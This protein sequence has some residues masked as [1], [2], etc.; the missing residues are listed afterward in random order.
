MRAPMPCPFGFPA[1]VGVKR[2]LAK[3]V[4]N[5]R[6]RE[7]L[8][9]Y[10]ELS[11]LRIGDLVRTCDGLNSRVTRVEPDYQEFRHGRVLI[12]LDIITDRNSCSLYH[13]G[14]DRPI[15]GAQALAYR[16]ALV[17]HATATG[18]P[19]GFAQRYAAMTINPDGT[20]QR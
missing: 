17:A 12:D 19:Y 15:T 2:R 9:R 14:V 11:R 16:D 1:W 20:Y 6:G 7:L 4:I 8:V 18:D 10:R 3:K 5:A 13:C